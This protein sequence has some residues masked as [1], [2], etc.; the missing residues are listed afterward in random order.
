MLSKDNKATELFGQNSRHEP[1]VF[2]EIPDSTLIA[3]VKKDWSQF[4]NRIISKVVLVV[5]DVLHLEGGTILFLVVDR[6]VDEV[7]VWLADGG[8][9]ESS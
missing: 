3:G 9:D 1:W 4:V 6:G 5:N 7:W 2:I 8:A